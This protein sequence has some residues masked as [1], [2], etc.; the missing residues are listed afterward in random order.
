MGKRIAVWLPD[1]MV[2][3]IDQL[4]ADGR[5]AS[6]AAVVGKAP[7]RERRREIAARDA[8]ILATERGGSDMES[9]AAYA[10]RTAPSLD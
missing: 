10:A 4:V 6:R 8:T 1:D 3:F 7:A 5:A 2:A 9:L